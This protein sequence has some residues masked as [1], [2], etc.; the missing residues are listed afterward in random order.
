[1][2]SSFDDDMDDLFEIMMI[3]K[4]I[5]NDEKNNNN[6]NGGCLPCILL[7]LGV[8]LVVIVL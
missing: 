4:E 5:K 6:N 2:C 8:I 1:M 3:E 7:S